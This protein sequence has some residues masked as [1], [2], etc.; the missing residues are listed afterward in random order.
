MSLKL[1]AA[2][3]ALMGAIVCGVG[4][5]ALIKVGGPTG[6]TPA[7]N[8][9]EWASHQNIYVGDW[10]YF[11]FE[12]AQYDVLEVNKTVYESCNSQA[13]FITNVTRGGRDVIQLTQPGTYYFLCSRG[14]CWNGMKVAVSVQDLPSQAPSPGADLSA[15]AGHRPSLLIVLL[16]L[17]F[18]L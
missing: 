15:A 6:W 3:V 5:A 18:F 7:T 13:G 9:T 16:A 17:A 8:Y 10:L 12:K 1:V 11:V 14:Y 4:S 2:V